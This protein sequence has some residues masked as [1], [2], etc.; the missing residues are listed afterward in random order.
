MSGKQPRGGSSAL[1]KR[2]PLICRPYVPPPPLP[3]GPSAFQP[4]GRV[5]LHN[6]AAPPPPSG[7]HNGQGQ[8]PPPGPAARAPRDW[9]ILERALAHEE[10]AALWLLE[11]AT[12]RNTALDVPWS[13]VNRQVPHVLGWLQQWVEGLGRQH[14]R[15][16]K[17]SSRWQPAIQQAKRCLPSDAPTVVS[18]KEASQEADPFPQHVVQLVRVLRS[19]QTTQIAVELIRACAGWLALLLEHRCSEQDKMDLSCNQG[20]KRPAQEEEEGEEKASEKD[21][22]PQKRANSEKA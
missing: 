13:R 16:I 6:G 1:E 9:T 10:E 22:P 7:S 21:G 2:R 15:V 11:G 8:A 19:E 20:R 17:S 5:P 12:A 3:S 4:V 14:V 18:I